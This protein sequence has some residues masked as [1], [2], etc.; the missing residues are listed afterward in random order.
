MGTPHIWGGWLR[1]E[2]GIFMLMWLSS[3]L[4]RSLKEVSRGEISTC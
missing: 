2:F 4:Y 1:V 3:F